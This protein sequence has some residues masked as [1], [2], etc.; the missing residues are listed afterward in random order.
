MEIRDHPV[1]TGP[2]RFV[3]YLVDDRLE[4]TAFADYF[5]GRPK[6]AGVIFQIT[7]DDIMRGLELKKGTVDLV[8]NELAPDVVHQLKAVSNLQTMEAPGVDYQYVGLNLRDPILRDV[9]VRQAL[10]Y[11]IDRRAIVEYL[12]RGPRDTG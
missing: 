6:N 4:V 1:G 3:R 7:P 11:A 5:A 8:V 2:Y 9:R 12:R 10:A